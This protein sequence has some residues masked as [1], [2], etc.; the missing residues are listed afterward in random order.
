MTYNAITYSRRLQEAGLNEK[1]ADIS[2]EQI[3]DIINDDLLTKSYFT[4]YLS[5]ALNALE[6]KMILWMIGISFAQIGLVLS[7]LNF[8][9]KKTP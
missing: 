8:I 2:A 5:S 3:G 4:S 9:I 6:N 1:I 7:L